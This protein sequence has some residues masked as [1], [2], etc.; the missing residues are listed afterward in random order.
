MCGTARGS[1]LELFFVFGIKID[2]MSITDP[3]GWQQN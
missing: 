2:A 1:E 3:A